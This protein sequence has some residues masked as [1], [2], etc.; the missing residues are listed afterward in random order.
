VDG[1]ASRA[2]VGVDTNLPLSTNF[3]LLLGA[4][5][6]LPATGKATYAGN[7]GVLYSSEAIKGSARAGFSLTGDKL[8]QVYTLG[9]VF[10]PSDTLAFSPSL[11]YTVGGSEGWGGRFSI[12]GAIRQDDWTLVTNNTGKFGFYAPAIGSAF[13]GEVRFGYQAAERLFL[14]AGIGYGLAG[15]RFIGQIGGGLTYYFTDTLGLG[16]NAAYQ[17]SPAYSSGGTNIAA[18]SNLVVGIEG[19]LRLL[20]GLNLNAGFNIGGI[21]SGV[22]PYLFS[23]GFYVRLEWKF[24]ERTFGR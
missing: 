18:T 23:P 11:E 12:A 6:T 9:G 3:S 7:F 20:T 24:D 19:S 15:P 10:Q 17:F 16:L 22:N 2:R 14:R 13:E 1:N 21:D 5:A 4:E 8:K